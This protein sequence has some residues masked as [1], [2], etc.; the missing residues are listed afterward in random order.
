MK[1]LTHF[2]RPYWKANKRVCGI[3]EAG[4]GPLAGPVV[5]AGV[6]LKPD[7]F[8]P[9]INDSKQTSEKKRNELYQW[10]IDHAAWI[11]IRIVNE[12]IIDQKNIYI[13]TQDAMTEIAFDSQADCVF[14][15]AMPLMLACDFESL[16]KGDAKSVSIASASIIAKVARD[17]IMSYYDE[18]Y[19]QYGFKQHKGY[20]TKLH[21]QRIK[22]FGIT[23]IHRQSFTL[24]KD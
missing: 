10:I 17:R 2:E 22:E 4:R 14:S 3:D 16:I 18:L 13:A 11:Q 24:F 15:D 19:P 9:D 23:P 12:H 5:V 8:H 1:D 21:Y 7:V 6:I 20:P